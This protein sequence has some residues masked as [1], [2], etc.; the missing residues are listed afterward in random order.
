MGKE[1][2]IF[3]TYPPLSFGPVQSPDLPWPSLLSGVHLSSPLQPPLLFISNQYSPKSYFLLF[4][5]HSAFLFCGLISSVDLSSSISSFLTPV[6]TFYPLICLPQTQH[7][8]SRVQS[9]L[10]YFHLHSCLLQYLHLTWPHGR[11]RRLE[12]GR[13]KRRGEVKMRWGYWPR[14]WRGEVRWGKGTIKEK[15]WERGDSPLSSPCLSFHLRPP[16]SNPL[17]SVLHFST[18]STQFHPSSHFTCLYCP[19]LL[20]SSPSETGEESCREKQRVG[21]TGQEAN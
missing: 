8:I 7:P 1:E 12:I 4:P 17:L 16:V 2:F 19:H 3:F 10:L 21:K 9:S 14:D 20:F 13:L 11:G 18:I 15:G 6:S 5:L